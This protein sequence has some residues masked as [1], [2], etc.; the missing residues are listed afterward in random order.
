MIR[1]GASK[2]VLVIVGMLFV[3]TVY[4]ML[5]LHDDEALQMMFSLYFTLGIL[6]LLASRNPSAP[7][8]VTAFAA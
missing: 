7:R 6:L 2:V 1:E 5:T 4:P 8:S 3:A